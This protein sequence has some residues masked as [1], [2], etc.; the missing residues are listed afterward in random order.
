MTDIKFNVNG[1]LLE[2]VSEPLVVAKSR[3]QYRTVFQFSA[4]WN[5]VSEKTAV[6]RRFSDGKSFTADL[7]ENGACTVPWEVIEAPRFYVSVFG[8]NLRTATEL[9]VNVEKTG[10]DDDAEPSGTVPQRTPV[11]TDLQVN[12]THLQLTA[13]GKPVGEGVEIQTAESVAKAIEEATKNGVDGIVI[14]DNDDNA[15][16]LGKFRISSGHPALEITKIGG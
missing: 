6:F 7:D 15:K 12:G 10:Y 8:G 4:D 13:K 9:F 14:T 2:S 16:Y 1:Q 3:N 11:P 5:G